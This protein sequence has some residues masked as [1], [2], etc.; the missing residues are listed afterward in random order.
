[1]FEPAAIWLAILQQLRQQEVFFIAKVPAS[2][3]SA[4]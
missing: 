4:Q 1:M 3:Q 2:V